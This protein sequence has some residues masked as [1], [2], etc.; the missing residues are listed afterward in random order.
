M[1]TKQAELKRCAYTSNLKSRALSILIY[2]IDRSNKDLT[3]FPAISTMATA[4]HIS[5]STV[6]RALHELVDAGFVK[7]DSRFRDNNRGQTSNLYTLVFKAEDHTPKQDNNIDHWDYIKPAKQTAT[8]NRKHFNT[9]RHITFADIALKQ[10]QT[11]LEKQETTPEVP[12]PL[13]V[14]P[15]NKQ[16]SLFSFRTSAHSAHFRLI[17]DHVQVGYRLVQCNPHVVEAAYCRW[18]GV[19]S[20]LIPP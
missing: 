17:R 15:H 1:I 5:V 6:K 8:T 4:L 13:E 7:K 19:E 2:L 16:S 3:C 12:Q 18:T 11:S 20:N 9:T 10:K 14:I